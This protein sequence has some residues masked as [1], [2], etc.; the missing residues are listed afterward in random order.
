MRSEPLA[1]QH[2]HAAQIVTLAHQRRMVHVQA[3]SAARGQDRETKE[4]GLAI[5]CCRASVPVARR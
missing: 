4:C 1:N 5:P 3:V 2:P